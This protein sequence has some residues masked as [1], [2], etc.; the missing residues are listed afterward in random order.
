MGREGDTLGP[1]CEAL[2]GRTRGVVGEEGED[3]RLARLAGVGFM[4]GP[5][6]DQISV[7]IIDSNIV[8]ELGEDQCSP[9]TVPYLA[10]S[11]PPLPLYIS[12]PT[13]TE[14]PITTGCRS[15]TAL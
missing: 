13:A 1:A 7:F 15:Q 5:Y 8:K 3:E 12:L 9:W 11:S 2:V 4:S 14:I 10:A 6:L